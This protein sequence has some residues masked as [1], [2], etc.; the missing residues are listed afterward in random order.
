MSNTS[1]RYILNFYNH[2]TWYILKINNG[3]E[4]TK[5]PIQLIFY[6]ETL[7]FLCPS[8]NPSSFPTHT[9]HRNTVWPSR[10]WTSTKAFSFLPQKKIGGVLQWHFKKTMFW[11]KDCFYWWQMGIDF[12]R[13]QLALGKRNTFENLQLVFAK[14][15]QGLSFPLA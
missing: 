1:I 12:Q 13:I 3:M 7:Y 10:M 11:D 8:P 4:L 6:T 14:C 9:R 2:K 15:H 5:F